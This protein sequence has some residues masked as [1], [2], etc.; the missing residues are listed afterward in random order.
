MELIMTR[1]NMFEILKKKYNINDELYRIT[2]L[3]N[4]NMISYTISNGI[5]VFR[6]FTNI[7]GITKK[8]FSFWNGRETC[9]DFEDM[10]NILGIDNIIKNNSSANQEQIIICLE[11]YVN[12]INLVKKLNKYQDYEHINEADYYM[13]VRN[14]NILLDHIHYQKYT[15][16]KEDKIIL[17]PKDPAAMAVAEQSSEDTSLAILMYNHAS[18]KGDL[19]CKKEILRKIAKEYENLLKDGINGFSEYFD[20]ARHMLNEFDIRHNNID[21]GKSQHKL[22]LKMSAKKIEEWLDE[23]YQLLLF[24]VLIKDNIARKSKIAEF[25]IDLHKKD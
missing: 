4:K 18:L 3:F 25:L 5:S 20:K 23:L 15:I 7:E 2:N 6:E 9:V 21:K 1:L 24:C 12:M 16:E 22:I 14:I 8:I 11:Y 13:L 17:I 19:E 10:R